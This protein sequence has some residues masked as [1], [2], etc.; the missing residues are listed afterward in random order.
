M[1]EHYALDRYILSLGLMVERAS[2]SGIHSAIYRQIRS[3]DV[4]GLRTG[5]ERHHCSDLIH[6]P[7]PVERCGSLLRYRP[8]TCGWV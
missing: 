7:V 3:C 4:R 6:V 5:D 8:T 2:G 1:L